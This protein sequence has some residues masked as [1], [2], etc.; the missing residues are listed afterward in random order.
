MRSDN[1]PGAPGGGEKTAL[2]LVRRGGT[3]EQIY[4]N[5]DTLEL[6]PAVRR[7]LTEGRDMA[8]LLHTTLRR[9]AAMRRWIF[10][11]RTR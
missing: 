9:S 10:S 2:D 8:F 1:I 3:L 4:Q 6:K 5:L 7:K 11:R